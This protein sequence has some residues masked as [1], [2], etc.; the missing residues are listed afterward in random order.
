MYSIWSFFTLHKSFS[1]LVLIA[2]VGFGSAALITIP[3]ESAPEVQIPIAIV[4]VALPGASALDIEK[5]ITNKVETALNNSL[6]DVKKITSSSQEGFS[7]VVIEFLP[8]AN[9]DD[10]VRDVKDE[11][12]K[13]KPELPSDATDPL[14]SDVNFVNQP[15]IT[16]A[17]GS[18]LPSSELVELADAVEEEIKKVEGVSDV[19]I[20]GY[21]D[22]ETQVIV[23]KEALETY[24]LRLI[25]LIGVIGRANS[26]FPVG[27]ILVDDIAYNVQ[28][29]GDI[30][31]PS[32][33]ANIAVA[34]KNGQPIYVRDIATVVDGLEEARSISRISLNGEP[35]TSALSIQVFKRSGGDITKITEAV[36]A[37]IDS[38]KQEGGILSD[39]KT[40]IVFDNGTELNDDLTSLGLSGFQTV[41]LVMIS[42]LLVIGWREAFI[43]GSAIPLSFLLAFI[44]LEATGNTLNF[45]SL[46]AL[47]L[48]VGVL[49]DS[50]IVMVEAINRN[51][52]LYPEEDKVRASLRA[53]KEFSAPITSGTLTTV[54]VFLPLF[55]ISGVTGEFIASIPFTIIF[56][57]I[58][59]LIVAVA[60]VPLFAS[61]ALNRRES[62]KFEL[63]QIEKFD[64]V[65]AWYRRLL[66]GIIGNKKYE[67]MII[68]GITISFFT[69][70]LFPVL[71][72]VKVEFFPAGDSDYIIVEIELQEGSPLSNTD[73]E[74]RKLEEILYEYTVIDSFV[75]TIGESSAFSGSQSVSS[76]T[77]FANA[78]IRLNTDRNI[79]SQE[80][81]EVLRN[82]VAKIGTSQVRVSQIDN[83]PPVGT[84]MLVKFFGDDLAELD[85]VVNQ[86]SD[87]LEDID[88]AADVVTSAKND[89]TQFIVTVDPIKAS[90]LGL[91]V[92]TISQTLRSAVSGITA[93]SI[94][95]GDK[96]I[97]VVVKMNLNPNYLDAHD[98]DRTTIDAL[99]QISIQTP[100]G[101]VLLGSLIN[102]SLAKNNTVIQ[103]EGLKRIASIG[104]QIS[105]DGNL[106][107]VSSEFERRA[108]EE[109]DL[110][111]VTMKIG[112]ENE[113]NQQA[114]IEM[115]YALIVGLVLMLAILVYEF[116]SYRHALYVLSV[117]PLALI[118]IMIG[119]L[120]TGKALSFPTLM[121]FIALMGIV[122]NNSIILIDTLNAMRRSDPNRDIREIILLGSASRLR[123]IFLTTITTV[124]GMVPLTYADA[125]WAPL[126]W[127][128]I[129]GLSFSVVLTL[130]L[131]PILYSRKPGVLSKDYS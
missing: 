29:E 116:G 42:L 22:R 102:V 55:F 120:V 20:G 4:S 59:S 14:V 75:I 6:E 32:E 114:F 1:Y 49:V 80:L 12:D 94:I 111:N 107:E 131:I 13:V 15:I 74:A 103:H 130:V 63:L 35:S 5:L 98:T 48:A 128:I 3:K 126:A 66:E 106:A 8:S 56:V 79:T 38:L 43:A 57:L 37:R 86:A 124:I 99:S 77:K 88:G 45:V 10:S 65:E 64:A 52:R 53:V 117:T 18:D 89:G 61:V 127:A 34:S 113:E 69:A 95:V 121:G 60:F 96:D 100:N 110:G 115:F 25:D 84:P 109:L 67:R 31:T 27:N 46:F 71:G 30:D 9:I 112:G 2:L 19:T 73:L 129:F 23:R 78:F 92:A 83:G 68:W 108:A 105:A 81:S 58:A 104:S 36:K 101:P 70:M 54:A 85:A 40:L 28:F 51:L 82:E 62:S 21:R 93:T 39:A 91:D 123:P 90:S 17:I 47:I 119:L 41:V 11:V 125:L 7:T 24:G 16:I 72:L 122:V 44:A 76:G 97:D 87:I 118:G 50:A 33:I 26:T